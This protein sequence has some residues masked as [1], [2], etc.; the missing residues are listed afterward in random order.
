MK[1]SFP[2][3]KGVIGQRT[4]YA[5][6]MKLSAIPKMFTFRDWAEFT[7]EQREQ[8]VLNK[9]RVPDIAHY[10]TEN[11]DGYLFS[12][13]TASYKSPVTFAPVTEGASIGELQMEFE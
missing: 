1:V 8:R 7:P 2:A 6:T 9:K 13:I 11:E 10:I 4:Y 3:M 12:S 5:C